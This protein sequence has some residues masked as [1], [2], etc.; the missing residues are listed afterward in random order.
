MKVLFVRL[1][2]VSVLSSDLSAY[3]ILQGNGLQLRM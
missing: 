3:M 2:L 1:A